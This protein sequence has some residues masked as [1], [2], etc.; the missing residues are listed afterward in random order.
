MTIKFQLERRHYPVL[1]R[2]A[3]L[4]SSTTGIIPQYACDA[5]CAYLRER[6]ELGMDI[7]T[8]HEQWEF[9]DLVRCEIAQMLG[10][11]GGHSIAYGQNSST[12]FN[13][14]CNGLQLRRGDNVVLY[15]T[16]FPAM[17]YQWLNLQ[18]LLGIELRV[19]KAENGQITPD[20][21]FDLIDERTR[22]VTVCHV[23]SGTG[24]RHDLKTIGKWCRENHVPFGVDAT[25]SCG[26]MQID[27]QDM[28][29]DFLT[30]S[31]YKWLQGVQGLAFAYVSPSF[32]PF[33]LQTEMGWANVRDRINGNPFNLDISQTACRFENGGLPAPGLY[34]LT[35]VLHTYMRLGAEDIQNYILDLSEYLHQRVKETPGLSMAFE[36]DR[37]HSSNLNSIVIPKGLELSDRILRNAGIRAKIGSGLIRVGIHYFNNKRDIDRLVDFLKNY[38]K[39]TEVTSN[40]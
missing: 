11:E 3:Y 27:V 21:L 10:A 19:A 39:E 38:M 31:V 12:M 29:I 13:L 20:A 5:M 4:D 22:A 8:Y 16:A 25:Q 37:N 28:K 14:F 15:E 35:E 17:T 7:Q 24:Y 40:E 1:E 30:S 2:Y 26:A 23:D 18:R 33:L 9:A 34:G 36:Y 32:M 6:S